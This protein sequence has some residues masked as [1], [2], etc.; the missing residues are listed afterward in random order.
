MPQIGGDRDDWLVVSRRRGKAHGQEHCGR[1]DH[2][3]YWQREVRDDYGF[4]QS[5]VRAVNDRYVDDDWRGTDSATVKRSDLRFQQ[6][7]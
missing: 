5:R 3:G 6:G 2:H 1:N 4:R 7:G